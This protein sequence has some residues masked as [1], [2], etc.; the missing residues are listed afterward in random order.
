[1]CVVHAVDVFDVPGRRSQ[2]FV[3]GLRRKTV[4]LGAVHRPMMGEVSL[5][6]RMP[7]NPSVSRLPA[8]GAR[9]IALRTVRAAIGPKGQG[10][11][12]FAQAT[13]HHGKRHHSAF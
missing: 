6:R 12:Y 4:Q 9:A 13:T 7:A 1:M 8:S 2:F 10:M 5:P 3:L 11:F